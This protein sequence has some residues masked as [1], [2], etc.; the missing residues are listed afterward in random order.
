MSRKL[1][2][3]IKQH[4]V[5][6]IHIA[7]FMLV[8]L[9]AAN[10]ITY[11]IWADSQLPGDAH[12]WLPQYMHFDK[13]TKFEFACVSKASWNALSAKQQQRLVE[14]LRSEFATLYFDEKDIPA[15]KWR[16]HPQRP[17]V[18]RSL[19][20]GCILDWKFKKRF[21]LLQAEYSDW[22]APLAASHSWVTYIWFFGIWIGP[23]PTATMVS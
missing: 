13:G 10:I 17:Q 14:T 23:W 19:K 3:K 5:K 8:S 7:I 1:W 22:E 16:H 9:F 21:L 11:I 4:K 12:K 2:R 15:E 20:G 18:K 6:T